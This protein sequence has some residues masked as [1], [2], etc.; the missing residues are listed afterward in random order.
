MEENPS[1][2]KTPSPEETSGPGRA[3]KASELTFNLPEE[4]QL[5]FEQQVERLKV[6]EKAATEKAREYLEKEKALEATKFQLEKEN[7]EFRTI[8]QE[9]RE[10]L[11]KRFE[12]E[13]EHN[14]NE[15]ALLKKELKTVTKETER[16]QK[17]KNKLLEEYESNRTSMSKDFKRHDEVFQAK[18]EEMTDISSA[19]AEQEK[20][21]R[22]KKEADSKRIQTREQQLTKSAAAMS[23]RL[24]ELQSQSKIL[25]KERKQLKAR[26]KEDY[27]DQVIELKKDFLRRAEYLT[28]HVDELSEQEEKLGQDGEKL[29]LKEQGL[30][31]EAQTK[32]DQHIKKRQA[33]L[34]KIENKLQKKEK[35]LI[36]QEEELLEER[37]MMSVALESMKDHVREN[38][39]PLKELKKFNREQ[40]K[41]IKVKKKII[42]TYD[43]ERKGLRVD[44]EERLKI[45]EQEK[46]DAFTKIQNEYKPLVNHRKKLRLIEK[47]LLVREKKELIRLN[48]EYD[49]LRNSFEV[50]RIVRDSELDEI[51]DRIDDGEDKL[52]KK[53][54]K[55]F[56]DEREAAKRIAENEAIILE[57]VQEIQEARESS[58]ELQKST[59]SFLENFEDMYQKILSTQKREHETFQQRIAELE[60]ESSAIKQ[61]MIDKEVV[62]GT[63]SSAQEL[64]A[65][66]RLK[67]REDMVEMMEKELRKRVEDYKEYIKEINEVKKNLVDEDE[68]RKA[69][70]MDNLVGYEEKLSNLGQAFEELSD[71]FHKEQELGNI[72]IIPEED[73]RKALE[74]DDAL[75]KAE[76]PLTIRHHL[77]LTDGS[78]RPAHIAE[79]I[80]KLA[81]NWEGLIHIPPGSFQM[82]KMNSRDSAP[83]REVT[84]EKPF[85]MRKYPV[86]NLEFY[87]FINESGYK[88]EAQT[89]VDGIVYHHGKTAVEETA[90]VSAKS[91]FFNPTLAPD[92]SA[93]WMCPDGR[94]DSLNAKFCHPVT[95][96]TW[97]D[98]QEY[99]Q[100]KSE[101]TGKKVRLPTEAEWEFVGGNFGRLA[102]DQFYFTE[103]N[104]TEYCNIEEA[105]IYGTTRVDKFQEHSFNNGV[106]DMFGNVFEWVE[107]THIR[108]SASKSQS[109]MVYKVVRG[110]SFIT[111][112][113]HIAH[114]RRLAFLT[115]YCTSF[116]GFRTVCEEE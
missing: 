46:A 93:F 43:N 51:Q 53:Q 81:D 86:T 65:Q 105:E 75:A 79:Y 13:A 91:T 50:D 100:W 88:T 71:A 4:L 1:D 20:V 96:V 10:N 5:E 112:F 26:M 35:K 21:F 94:P 47:K 74:Y 85:S 23:Q 97:A 3:F 37:E 61:S 33:E 67:Q 25:A 99:C 39:F 92:N 73:E 15:I 2:K 8:L 87:R 14:R 29:R 44:F 52:A 22:H 7:T 82:G 66:R 60:N 68:S 89:F 62:A 113:H 12:E 38:I 114:W 11:Q 17:E 104:I 90:G 102:P 111:N 95:Q 59:Q 24:K 40:E 34:D 45:F 31:I 83:Y 84:I 6:Q 101:E 76:W 32:A 107:D 49:D 64:S 27:D 19:L 63:K 55:M 110:G 42:K 48:E 116:L 109:N 78:E 69:E 77:G 56:N 36:K 115:N 80:Y 98:A 9:Q 18:F 30:M 57:H 72:E 58:A 106:C 41:L 103:K 108:E 16:L 54:D 28:R 70:L